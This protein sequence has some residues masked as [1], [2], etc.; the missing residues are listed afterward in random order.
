VQE[1]NIFTFVCVFALLLTSQVNAQA[2]I[3]DSNPPSCAGAG[4][5]DKNLPSIVVFARDLNNQKSCGIPNQPRKIRNV[6]H[7][8]DHDEMPPFEVPNRRPIDI[9]LYGIDPYLQTC[10]IALTDNFVTE[11]SSTV[12]SALG[13][14]VQGSTAV[15]PTASKGAVVKAAEDAKSVAQ[16][17]TANAKTAEALLKKSKSGGKFAPLVSESEASANE[18][19]VDACVDK[20]TNDHTS[21]DVLKRA[22]M[23]FQA[24]VDE[25][26]NAAEDAISAYD[27]LLARAS[28][29]QMRDWKQYREDAEDL[30]LIDPSEPVLGKRDLDGL[31]DEVNAD[32]VPYVGKTY[33]TVMAGLAQQADTLR[34]SSQ[35]GSACAAS[36]QSVSDEDQ[37]SLASIYTDVNPK[38]G[39]GG[40]AE[41]S[42]E[43]SVKAQ[44]V[45]IATMASTLSQAKADLLKVLNAPAA[46]RQIHTLSS[47]ET[48]Q[49]RVNVKITCTTHDIGLKPISINQAP[50]TATPKGSKTAPAPADTTS[51]PAKSTTVTAPACGSSTA[52][53]QTGCFT[54]NFGQGQRIFVTGGFAFAPLATHVYST[55][56]STPAGS[57]TAT[58]TVVDTSNSK[59]KI[60]ALGTVSARLF[61]MDNLLHQSQLE[62][63]VP[64]YLSFGVTAS[65]DSNKGTTA[66]YLM[67]P[68]FASPGQNLFLTV[69]AFGGAVEQLGGGLTVGSITSL[70]AANLPITQQYH[71][72]VGF[73]IT[74][75]IK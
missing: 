43:T 73:S 9:V 64:N 30:K 2:Q 8:E 10:S 41:P 3:D 56:T 45:Q 4:L 12:G 68:S 52:N 14:T 54:V 57:T 38:G 27:D 53:A 75:K 74:Y 19:A 69:G 34:I 36:M 71:W 60:A 39:T 58:T 5:G 25:R 24:I 17:Q 50:S 11:S 59:S 72:K 51:N 31:A 62:F 46:V 18:A 7:P 26:V 35:P 23:A 1:K 67:G 16:K 32:L 44:I 37:A 70:S 33:T 13:I 48:E 63:L 55:S 6:F 29:G 47:S 49:N 28:Y 61:D 66:T 15:A 20:F 65:A 40:N 21:V 22:V 42:V